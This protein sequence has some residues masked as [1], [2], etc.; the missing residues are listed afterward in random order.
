MARVNFVK[1][2]K[3]GKEYTVNESLQARIEHL[4]TLYSEQEYTVQALNDVVAQQDR[5]ISRLTL[6]IE[7]LKD[8]I[9]ALKTEAVSD[10]SSENEIPPHY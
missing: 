2:V 8:Q 9:N 6:S 7:R 4:E 5:E 10:I 1:L 3:F